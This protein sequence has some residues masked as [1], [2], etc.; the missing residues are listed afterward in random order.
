MINSLKEIIQCFYTLALECKN[1]YNNHKFE[2]NCLVVGHCVIAAGI[3]V[4]YWCMYLSGA[5]F[6]GDILS[7]LLGYM[8]IG[9]GVLIFTLPVIFAEE[10]GKFKK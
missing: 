3:I 2:I 5:S 1:Y 9:I 10:E 7:A 4:G 6:V 8:I